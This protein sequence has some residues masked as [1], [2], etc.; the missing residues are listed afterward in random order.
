MT[1]RF[2][3]HSASLSSP[4]SGGFPITPDDT[5]DLPEATRGLYVGSGG[6]LS[7]VMLSGESLSFV[8][9]PDGVLLPL[10]IQRVRAT[11]TTAGDMIGLV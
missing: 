2:S 7:V 4:A 9:V 1:D 11:G 5:A 10:R 3:S 8:A 6:D